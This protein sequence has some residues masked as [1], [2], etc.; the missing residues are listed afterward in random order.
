MTR[1]QLHDFLNRSAVDYDLVDG[2]LII[3]KSKKVQFYQ[4]LNVC[5]LHKT[6][7]PSTL[8]GG[9]NFRSDLLVRQTTGSGCDLGQ[10]LEHSESAPKSATAFEDDVAFGPPRGQGGD[11]NGGEDLEDAFS[12]MVYR[13]GNFEDDLFEPGSH[14]G[15]SA[16]PALPP[17]SNDLGL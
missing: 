11:C 14:F 15:E 10:N 12:T 4:N 1:D 9:E 3:R 8:M 16:G 5:I 7:S 6:F 13:I 17:P 2:D